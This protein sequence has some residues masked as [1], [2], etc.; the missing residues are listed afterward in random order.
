MKYNPESAFLFVLLLLPLVFSHTSSPLCPSSHISNFISL[1]HEPSKKKGV[2]V[3]QP[4]EENSPK[5]DKIGAAGQQAG[6]ALL[7]TTII[8]QSM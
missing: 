6:G 3:L 1:H 7:Y 8:A 4:G 5:M 2:Y